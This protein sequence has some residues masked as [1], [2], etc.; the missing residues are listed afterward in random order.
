[1]CSSRVRAVDE[2]CEARPEQ[3]PPQ[4]PLKRLHCAV[5]QYAWGRNSEDSEVGQGAGW[6]PFN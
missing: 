2:A 4:V 1:M 6:L 3:L 5:Q